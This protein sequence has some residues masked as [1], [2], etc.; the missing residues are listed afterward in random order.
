MIYLQAKKDQRLPAKHQKL[1]MR[2]GTDSYSQPSEGINPANTLILNSQPPELWDNKNL[3]LKPFG[4]W[5]FI[6]T[7]LAN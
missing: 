2:H 7:A 1:G 5:Y 3:L 4:L 6:M